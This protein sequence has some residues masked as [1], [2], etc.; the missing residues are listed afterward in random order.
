MNEV[1]RLRSRPG[2]GGTSQGDS[3]TAPKVAEQ[4][5][6]RQQAAQR[7]GLFLYTDDAWSLRYFKEDD[8][9]FLE[10]QLFGKDPHG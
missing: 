5:Q 9:H 3:G 7:S 2:N 4:P 6:S 1:I 10:R 8:L